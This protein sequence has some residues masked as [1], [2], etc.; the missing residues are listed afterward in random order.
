MAE[1]QTF[2]IVVTAS[3]QKRY[4]QTILVYLLHHFSLERVIEIE[5]SLGDE[6]QSLA[7]QP[8]RGTRESAIS[9]TGPVCRFMLFKETRILELKIIYVVDEAENQVTVTD[10]FPT[11]M[12]PSKIGAENRK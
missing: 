6:I 8:L 12:D 3:A 11:R 9:Q 4:R 7:S 1:N 10:L 5:D 2:K